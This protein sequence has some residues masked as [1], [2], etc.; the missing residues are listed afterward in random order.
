MFTILQRI[1]NSSNVKLFD[2]LIS[3]Q[4]LIVI[5]NNFNIQINKISTF[6]TNSIFVKNTQEDILLNFKKNIRRIRR[7]QKQENFTYDD[8]NLMSIN[9]TL[10]EELMKNQTVS[11]IGFQS[12]LYKNKNIPIETS[13]IRRIFSESSLNFS[14][15]TLDEKNDKIKNSAEN[16]KLTFEIRL[17]IPPKNKISSEIDNAE[18]INI[19][20]TTCIQ[21]SNTTKPVVSCES[22]YDDLSSEVVCVCDKQGFTVN[23]SDKA[24]SYI[25][26]LKQFP[27]LTADISNKII[28]ISSR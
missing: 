17:K 26:K 28:L 9:S 4:G 6:N 24:L 11:N 16:M 22:W 23:V 20:D 27:H 18:D 8:S 5:K 21:Y 2:N 19:G 14:L 7:L 1:I 25:S 3:G 12:Q 10:L 13:K 15:T